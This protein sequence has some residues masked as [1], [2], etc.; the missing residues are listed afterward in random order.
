MRSKLSG[1]FYGTLKTI[2]VDG[3]MWKMDQSEDAFGL[4][5]VDNVSGT[6]Y[7]F[8]PDNGFIFD[9]ASIPRPARWFYPKTGRGESGQYGPAATIHDWLYSYPGGLDR[10]FCDRVFLLGMELKEVRYTMRSLFYR[11]VR[12][13]GWRYFGKPDKLNKMRSES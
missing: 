4:L 12:I 7:T 8:E 5:V 1:E 3:N 6:Q 9:F 10:K 11:A 2:Y 13:G